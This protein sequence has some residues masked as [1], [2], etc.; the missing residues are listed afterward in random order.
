MQN[1]LNHLTKIVSQGGLIQG[2]QLKALGLPRYM[3]PGAIIRPSSTE[4]VAEILKLC[5]QHQQSIVPM[6]GLTG[7]VQGTQCNN[8]DIGLWLQR[9]N[10]I[11]VIDNQSRTMTVQAGTALQTIQEAAEQA[12]LIFPLDLG[13]RGSATIGGNV[14]TNAGGNRVIRYGMTREQILGMEV[15]LADGTILSSMKKI[16]KDNTGY[17]LKQLFIGSEGTLGIVTRVVLKL[18]PAP[19]TQDMAFIGTN[20]FKQ[21]TDFLNFAETSLGGS[22]SAYEVL[23]HDYYQL[24]TSPPASGKPPLAQQY[25]YYILL[26][27]L[28]GDSKNDHSR[29]VECL[30]Q[31]LENNLIDDAVI[32]KN[33]AECQAMWAIR[34]DVTQVRQ[35][36]PVFTFDV[37]I[38]LDQM[39]SYIEQLQLSLNT[40]WATNSCMV[41]GH[42]G[43][44]NL[45]LN[46]GVGDNS[47]ATREAV[48]KTVYSGL[49][50]RGG[51]ISAEHGVGIQKK[52]YLA[53]TKSATEIALMKKIKQA[54][55]PRHIL[56][57]NKIFDQSSIS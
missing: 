51:S 39:E 56:N 7:L 20:N 1:L 13:A 21:V 28:G 38:S 15:V 8:T 30:E 32:A 19:S 33:Q 37:S 35:N 26:E 4:E 17:D 16:T 45:H 48:V 31:A 3:Q 27:A 34:D 36:S 50:S 12:G 41:F 10:K 49:T 53:L 57:P 25:K 40:Q 2:E 14:A 43:D 29:F 9:M 52:K 44:G 11:E 24:V 23:W 6:G 54:F 46:I 18:R 55:D 22:L 42:L 5:H 47:T